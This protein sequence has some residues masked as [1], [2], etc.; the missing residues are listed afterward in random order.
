MGISEK[1]FSIDIKQTEDPDRAK[2][3]LFMES[4]S[5][6]FPYN[7]NYLLLKYKSSTDLAWKCN[8]FGE[9]Y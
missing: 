3:F 1:V 4:S 7:A 2:T 5:L 9:S 6:S 8:L